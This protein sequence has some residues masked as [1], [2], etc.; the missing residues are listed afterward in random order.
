[1]A[2][3]PGSTLGAY[4]VLAPLGAGGMGE[5]Y[6]ARDARLDRDVA[7]KI[8]AAGFTD[9]PEALKRF[10][11]EAKAV[12]A[13]SHPNILSIHDFG[14]EQG[15]AF[16]VMELLEGETLRSSLRQGKLPWRKAVEI[17][18][19]VADGLSAA[20]SKGIIHRDLKP[21]NIFITADGRVKILDFGLARMEARATAD[22]P[23]QAYGET[24]ATQPGIVM[25]TAGYMSP[26]Q[27]RG[28]PADAR[29]D[30]FSLGCV[31]HEMLT[32]RRTFSGE[33]G[34]EIMAAIVKEDLPELPD[35]ERS[36]P[37]ELDRVVRHCLEKN[38]QARF[39]SAQDLGFALRALSGSSASRV[40]AALPRERPRVSSQV[41]ALL[42]IVALALVFAGGLLLGSRRAPKRSYW[43]LPVSA[44]QPVL[45]Q[46][47][48]AH[49][50][51][52][53]PDGEQFVYVLE[54]DHE[55]YL[56]SIA[57]GAPR[58]LT[59]DG[60]SKFRP[61]F[62]PDGKRILY[63]RAMAQSDHL[64]LFVLDLPVALPRLLVGDAYAGAWSPDG[65]KLAFIRD[66]AEE[67][68]VGDAEG[69]QAHSIGAAGT[70]SEFAALSWSP[71]G[72]Q[73]VV[74]YHGNFF[75]VSP[76]GASRKQVPGLRGTAALFT[77]DGEYLLLTYARGPGAAIW[78]APVR[79]GSLVP[80][81]VQPARVYFP[82][83][84]RDGKRVLAT[85]FT[86]T[87]EI[88]VGPVTAAPTASEP[89]RISFGGDFYDP[90]ISP[91]GKRVVFSAYQKAQGSRG[92]WIANPDG[93]EVRQ[94]ISTEW[95]AAAPSWSPDGKSIVYCEPDEDHGGIWTV[96]LDDAVPHP[97]NTVGGEKLAPS[98]TSDGKNIVF[99][100]FRDGKRNL[101]MVPSEGGQGN[102]LT[103]D[104]IS[105]LPMAGPVDSSIAYLRRLA[106]GKWEIRLLDYR[107]RQDR[108]LVPA[109]TLAKFGPYWEQQPRWSRDG[110]FIFFAVNS[111]LLRIAVGTSRVEQFAV[112]MKHGRFVL[113]ETAAFDL[114]PD[115]KHIVYTRRTIHFEPHLYADLE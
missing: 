91:D 48:D 82:T 79:G 53:S 84:S 25:G 32:G 9:H 19:A 28:T 98:Y 83:L 6:R 44:P 113:G 10:E 100:V 29:S 27:V 58:K 49:W 73:I 114:F 65:G 115:Q 34:A 75:L 99:F 18:A 30:I 24:A 8:L 20:H 17:G 59:S 88:T 13:L 66:S 71:D 4:K 95:L 63:A 38:P 1:M 41:V 5:V 81:S 39:Q 21:E 54:Q 102:A 110:Q 42:G 112:P 69:R 33:S 64:A 87:G 107:S 74:P 105:E 97:L 12:A 11:R 35:S 26:E 3:S 46:S 90:A 14:S 43:K 51:T 96:R 57:G 101:W 22:G 111:A 31:L 15:T 16:A 106:E 56:Q 77:P 60:F 86:M 40:P 67:A 108:L 93:S 76:D 70:L 94:L 55:L 80:F 50:S 2:L 45:Q 85:F 104:G 78:Q 52:L 37:L 61:Q 72:N 109:E 103:S 36:F 23:T 47:G 62:S 7:I 92:L 89:I 68:F